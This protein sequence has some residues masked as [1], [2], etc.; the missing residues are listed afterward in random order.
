MSDC[1]KQL[2]PVLAVAGDWHDDEA[3]LVPFAAALMIMRRRWISLFFSVRRKKHGARTPLQSPEAAIKLI[4][5][6]FNEFYRREG[7]GSLFLLLLL[8]SALRHED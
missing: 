7:L 3:L 1:A 4:N 5:F 8:S 2:R 6:H